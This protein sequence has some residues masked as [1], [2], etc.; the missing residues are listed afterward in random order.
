MTTAIN[1]HS[2]FGDP[3]TEREALR[4]LCDFL[5]Y[6][7]KYKD[8]D[9]ARRDA[10][11]RVEFLEKADFFDGDPELARAS[12]ERKATLALIQGHELQN[13]LADNDGYLPPME[14]QAGTGAVSKRSITEIFSAIELDIRT[15]L[16]RDQI[17]RKLEDN[18][19]AADN[20]AEAY[21]V[22]MRQRRHKKRTRLVAAVTIVLL[23]LILFFFAR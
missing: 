1:Y 17:I 19:L 5:V 22:V 2:E 7:G 13:L 18:G 6:K 11:Q 21:D 16:S 4:Q 14:N 10:R 20:A 8:A 15:G 23:A 3:E 12:E 9:A